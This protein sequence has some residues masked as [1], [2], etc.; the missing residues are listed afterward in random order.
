MIRML[1]SL[2]LLPLA[3]AGASFCFAQSP[4]AACDALA[5]LSIP[6]AKIVNA[7]SITPS[8]TWEYPD[9]VFGTKVIVKRPFCRVQ[10]IANDTVGIEVWLPLEHWNHHFLGNGNGAYA[11]FI[12]APQLNAGLEL[13]YAAASTDTGHRASPMD[14]S[15]ARNH[16]EL[17]RD[18]GYDA[19][20]FMTTVSK[21]IVEAFYHQPIQS[22]LFMGCSGGGHQA[23]T[24]AQ[25]F[26]DDYNGILAGAPGIYFPRL[27]IR[28]FYMMWATQRIPDATI[29]RE[30]SRMVQ[31][32]VVSACDAR[33]GVEDG[34]ISDPGK[35]NFD[36]EMLACPTNVKSSSCLSEPQ[37]QAIRIL[38]G[39]VKTSDGKQVYPSFATGT[40]LLDPAVPPATGKVGLGFMQDFVFND[41]H[42]DSATFDIDRDFAAVES[43]LGSTL[44]SGNADLRPFFNKGGKLMVYH[45]WSDGA[46]SPYATVQY[47]AEVHRIS[48]AALTDA[49]SR[50]Y[51]IPGMEHCQGGAGT[52]IFGS[53]STA[54]DPFASSAQHNMLLSLQGWVDDGR[55]PGEIIAAHRTNGTIDRTRPLCPSPAVA[56]YKG[57]GSVDEAQNFTCAAP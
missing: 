15:W 41:P 40:L 20:H 9:A 39:A 14:S 42:W 51:M 26:P 37:V 46:V 8:P 4:S 32:A 49:D 30:Q 10:A 57:T 17:V 13:G 54:T 21:L 28:S 34:V 18:F 12:N 48:G 33:D 36:Y 25:R 19:Q 47:F 27:A 11:G 56:K 44:E 53:A 38:A 7:A 52:D 6:G 22:S 5:Q 45:G 31:R 23:L 35:C 29:S 24:E 55:A 3:F 1:K 50:V 43:K 2:L 16:P